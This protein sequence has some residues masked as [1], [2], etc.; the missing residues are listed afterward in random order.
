MEVIREL[1][2]GTEISSTPTIPNEYL[3]GINFLTSIG[4]LQD[5]TAKK[6]GYGGK[7]IPGGIINKIIACPV[8][9]FKQK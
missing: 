8:D 9:I 7:V 3:E 5:S 4:Q 6:I 1:V 2:D